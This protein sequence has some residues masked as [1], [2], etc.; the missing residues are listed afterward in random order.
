VKREN[1]RTHRSGDAGGVAVPVR[2]GGR[3]AVVSRS[4]A[5][6]GRPGR[7]R[8][9][10]RSSLMHVGRRVDYAVRAL[11][12]L[13]GQDPVRVVGRAEIEARQAIPR[14]FLSKIL[15][16]LVASGILESVPGA[17]GGFRL[18]RPAR[19]ITVRQVYA[20]LE[21]ELCLIDCVR[22]PGS[23]CCFASICTQIEVWRGAQRLLLD[24]LDGISIADIADGYGLR[25]RLGTAC[26]AP[27]AVSS[28]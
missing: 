16:A 9:G 6:G 7:P 12:Y 28:A 1:A 23:G 2:A 26:T 19:E 15:R 18:R 27:P 21:G 24:Y 5:A 17:H 8:T 4:A 13:A 14:Y 10:E 25:P 20:A 11:A 3:H 22:D